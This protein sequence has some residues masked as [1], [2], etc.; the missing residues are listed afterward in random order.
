MRIVLIGYG[1]SAEA[2]I[3]YLVRVVLPRYAHDPAECERVAWRYINFLLLPL[4][5][6]G[7]VLSAFIGY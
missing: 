5:A 3:V 6:L 4:L 1:L 2:I 7:I